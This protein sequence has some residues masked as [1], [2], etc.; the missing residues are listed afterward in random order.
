MAPK[1]T[2][3]EATPTAAATS[4]P[5]G[6]APK[7][8]ANPEKTEP[9]KPAASEQPVVTASP[10]PAAEKPLEPGQIRMGGAV[11]TVT[12]SA[13]P[14]PPSGIGVEV[15]FDEASAAD[16]HPAT[17][18]E[19]PANAAPQTFIAGEMERLSLL[20]PQAAELPDTGDKDRILEAANRRI[21][22]LTN[23]GRLIDRAPASSLLAQ[24]AKVAAATDATRMAFVNTLF[25]EEVAAAWAATK[26][27]QIIV[28]T[29]TAISADPQAIWRDTMR[30]GHAERQLALFSF[31]CDNA[32]LTDE[33]ET[34]AIGAIEKLLKKSTP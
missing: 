11:M 5:E 24:R 1:T 10:A 9:P 28:I 4:K 8:P 12:P 19:T 13:T 20:I 32:S 17:A 33:Q 2:P 26:V 22:L 30:Y 29:P 16:E 21:A 15:P 31:L 34:W 27:D 3:A 25:G 23:L 18:K 6:E 7:P 14:I